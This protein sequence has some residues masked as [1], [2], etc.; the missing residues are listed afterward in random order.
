MPSSSVPVT[1]YPVNSGLATGASG[2]IVYGG[3]AVASTVPA[4]APLTPSLFGTGSPGYFNWFCFSCFCPQPAGY[5]LSK[6]LKAKQPIR[7]LLVLAAIISIVT[8]ATM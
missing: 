3:A 8:A 2:T 4:P 1:Q 7:H 5:F 6:K